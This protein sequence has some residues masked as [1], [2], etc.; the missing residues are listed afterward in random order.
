MQFVKCSCY[1]GMILV[2]NT[3]RHLSGIITLVQSKIILS[4]TIEQEDHTHLVPKSFERIHSKI[5]ICSISTRRPRRSWSMVGGK[6][7]E[8]KISSKVQTLHVAFL[9]NKSLTWDKLQKRN[10]H[11]PG[12]CQLYKQASATNHHLIMDCKYTQEVWTRSINI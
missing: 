9:H 4:F 10:F 7:L 6:V 2:W 11:G 1:P 12:R 5:W 3:I 8:A